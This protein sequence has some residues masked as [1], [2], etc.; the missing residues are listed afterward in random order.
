MLSNQLEANR[1]LRKL[2]VCKLLGIDPVTLYHW[3]KAGEFPVGIILNPRS[4]ITAWK[5]SEVLEWLDSRQRG[6]LAP[7]IAANR[8]RRQRGGYRV[9]LLPP[10]ERGQQR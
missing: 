2:E 8:A 4:S 1:L 5:Q 6:L 7:P 10:S 3:I 9:R